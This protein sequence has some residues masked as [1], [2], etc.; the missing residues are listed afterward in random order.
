MYLRNGSQGLV[1]RF[2]YIDQEPKEKTSFSGFSIRVR[3]DCEIVESEFLY[4]L[5]SSADIRRQLT[6][7]SN[8]SNIKSLNQTLL[9]NVEIPIPSIKKQ[10]DILADLSEIETKIVEARKIIETAEERKK[11]I[12]EKIL[13]DF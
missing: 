8:G 13:M 2:M 3:P 12:I 5:L 9:S 1:G 6:I 4:Y 10:K 7:G 11:E